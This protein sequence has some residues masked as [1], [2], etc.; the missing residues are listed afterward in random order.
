[1]TVR[2]TRAIAEKWV[3]EREACLPGFVGAYLGGSTATLPLDGEISGGSDMDVYV[4]LRGEAPDKRGKFE[5]DGALLEVSYLNAELLF[6][7][8]KALRDYHLANSLRH[9]AVLCDPEGCLTALT[10][11]IAEKFAEREWIAARRDHALS[12]V[13]NG[14]TGLNRDA[15]LPDRTIAWLFST[16][17]SCHGIL[18][19]ALKNPTV[20][21]RYLR[22]KE[23]L[24]TWGRPDLYE[25]LLALSGFGNLTPEQASDLLD[26]AERAFDRAV[27]K[28]RTWFPFKSDISEVS[29]PAA[30]G[31]ARD[32][33]AKGLHRET[34]FWTL[35]TFARSMKMLQADALADYDDLLPEFQRAIATVNRDSWEKIQ[36]AAGEMLDFLPELTAETDALI[37][38]TLQNRT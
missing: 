16:G 3:R 14:L 35:T 11:E 26:G 23:V 21:L 25:R 12:R 2:E 32:M 37:D 17:I 7:A 1:M 9:R 22:A 33:I 20:R 24:E 15:T 29:R 18:V 10:D 13:K 31:A 8:E 4:V 28:G 19:A 30:I 34:A 6:P 36:T 5:T 27:E 38:F